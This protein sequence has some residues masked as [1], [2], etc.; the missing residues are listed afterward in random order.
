MPGQ[1]KLKELPGQDAHDYFRLLVRNCIETYKELPN[2]VICL[3]YN[4]VSGKLR[5]L[6][7]DDEEYKQETRNIYAR[8]RLEELQEIDSLAKLAFNEED[9]DEDTDPRRKGKKKKAGGADKDMLNMR[10]KAAQMRRELIAALDENNSASERDA[11]N[12]MFV[13][14]ARGEV[15]K[16]ARD[17]IYEGDADEALGELADGKE[18]APEGTS[19]KVQIS[20]KSKPLN[21]E[22]F[23]DV[24]ESG[25]IVER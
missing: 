11:V 15:E 1:I 20:G 24:L 13:G 4:K 8:Q 10:F 23:F 19:G 22:E 25:E 18:G 2:D 16:S 7:L 17:E 3:D 21:D 9:D 6:V 5:A 14:M 12:L